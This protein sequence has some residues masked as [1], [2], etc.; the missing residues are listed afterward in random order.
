MEHQSESTIFCSSGF[1]SEEVL[2]DQHTHTTIASPSILP[3]ASLLRCGVRGGWWGEVGPVHR[4][5]Y[6]SGWQHFGS[7]YR[8]VCV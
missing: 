1:V 3:A 8:R 4:A 5:V 2:L 6:Q 7:S